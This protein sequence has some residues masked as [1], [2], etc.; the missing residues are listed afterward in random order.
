[1]FRLTTQRVNKKSIALMSAAAL[2][3]GGLTAQA[4]GILNTPAGGYLVCVD[5]KTG[6]VTHP[7]T[8]KCKK[9]QKR[10]ILGAQGPVGAAGA[11][12]A[13]GQDGLVGASG[14]PGKAGNTLWSGNGAPASTLGIPGDS[15]LDVAG[16]KIHSPKGIDGIWPAGI[17]IVGPQGP[18]GPGGSG[19]AGPAG[20]AGTAGVSAPVVTGSDCIGNKCTYKVGDIGP[21]GGYIFFVDYHDVY[22][23]INYLEVAPAGW[24]RDLNVP[25]YDEEKYFPNGVF[26][27][28]LLEWC[29]YSSHYSFDPDSTTVGSR[30][31]EGVDRFLMPWDLSRVGAGFGNTMIAVVGCEF[32]AVRVADDYVNVV[33]EKDDWF[34]PSI[35]ELM[36][37]YKNLRPLGIG[38]FFSVERFLDICYQSVCSNDPENRVEA[39]Y[40]SS[41]MYSEEEVWHQHFDTGAQTLG[42]IP[43][44]P[45]SNGGSLMDVEGEFVSYVR[46]IRSF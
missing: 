24:A 9:G 37:L 11:N 15:Y 16:K 35:G 44:S 14:L 10:L 17:S 23:G 1:M 40:W 5:T 42:G 22:D 7:G 19:P 43:I 4:S 8:S 34:L 46:P 38:S 18:Q 26:N 29:D 32:G 6:A 2:V 31:F 28:P 41:S 3:L 13:N 20:P 45:I 12:G 21:G 30:F 25:N 36:L 27:D 33:T 39:A